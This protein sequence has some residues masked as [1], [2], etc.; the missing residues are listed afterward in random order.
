MAKKQ[1]IMDKALELFAKQGFAATSVQQITEH[2]GISKGAFYLSF[3]SKDE[4][5]LALIDHFMMEI[6]SDIDRIVR[7]ASN[8][9]VLYAFYYEMFHSFLKRSDFG[10]VL[11]KEQTQT[12]NEELL[13][14]M[15]YYDNIMNQSILVMIDRLYGDTVSKTKYDLLFCIKGLMQSYSSLFFF[16]QAPLDLDLLARTLVEKTD[17]LARHTAIPFFSQEIFQ[18]FKHSQSG[19]MTREQI[20]AAIEHKLEELEESVEKESLTLLK[21]ELLEPALSSVIVRGLVEN[22]QRN[23]HCKWIY[24]QLCNYFG[25]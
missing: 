8:D 25:Y 12:F 15:R 9:E 1:F 16:N 2:C 14:K 5:I 4:L 11:F 20:L 23:P 24:Y 10:R 6:V 7:N 22:L 3:K 18:L 21:Q 17:L 19:K 13:L